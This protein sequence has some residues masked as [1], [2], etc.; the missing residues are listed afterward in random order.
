MTETCLPIV[1][2][3][4]NWFTPTDETYNYNLTSSSYN[5]D[6]GS[7]ITITV[8][9]TDGNGDAVSGES[10]TLYMNGTAQTTQT[11]NSSGVATWSVTVNK[12][13]LQDFRV[14]NQSIQV[15]VGGWKT[16]FSDVRWT[17][18]FNET[19]TRV[20]LASTVSVSVTTTETQ[21]GTSVLSDNWLRPSRPMM[22]PS[23]N[24]NV[25]VLAR[26]GNAKL[27]HRTI[28]G[29]VTMSSQYFQIQWSH[30]G[31]PSSY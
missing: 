21:Y 15:K 24:G 7:S 4:K 8:T 13:G 17:V 10:V 11:T 18:Q 23:Y 25:I 19:T 22:F 31:L 28:S 12:F 3:L 5:P 14:E 27:S 26:D 20:I 6:I 30:K 16:Y 2:W 9:V 1:N 29:S